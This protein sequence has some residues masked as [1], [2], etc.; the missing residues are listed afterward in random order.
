[1][2]KRAG[3]RVELPDDIVVN[4][5]LRSIN[6]SE[7]GM[8]LESFRVLRVGRELE[9]RIDLNGYRIDVIGVVRWSRASSSIYSDQ[10]RSGVQFSNLKAGDL[11]EVRRY[12][13][14]LAE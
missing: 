2:D 1:V 10:S 14:R 7:G 5:D 6:L 9:L 12:L 3:H 8:L 13:A 11:V 4:D